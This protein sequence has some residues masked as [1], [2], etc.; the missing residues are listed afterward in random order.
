VGDPRTVSAILVHGISGEIEVVGK[1]F[2]GVMPAFAKQ[3]KPAE[4]ASVISFVR[5]NWGNQ[6]APVNPEVVESVI[7]QT[8]GRSTP[9]KGGGELKEQVWK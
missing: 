5:S 4:I 3:L 1:P 9:W 2:K 8:S 6:A 7:E